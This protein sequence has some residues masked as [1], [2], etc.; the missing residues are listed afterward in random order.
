MTIA[1]QL[2]AL[3]RQEAAPPFEVIV[4]DNGSTD[5]SAE[6]VEALSS[7]APPGVELFVVDCSQRVGVSA[8][9]NAGVKASR[10]DRVLICDADDIV[11]PVWVREMM[12]ALQ[13]YDLVGGALDQATLNPDLVGTVAR[14]LDENLPISLGFL[15]FAMGAN[16]GARRKMIEA[17]GGWDETFIGGGDDVDFSWR[18]Q[19]AGYTI[20]FSEG[21][22]IAYRLRNDLKGACKQSYRYARAGPRL[23]RI[24][25]H[26]GARRRTSRSIV[27]SW[28]WI[29]SRAPV[30][31]FGSYGLRILWCRR[32]GLAFG[33]V[34]GSLRNRVLFL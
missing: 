16:V 8:A 13:T 6:I 11:S 1:D 26:L 5:R 4:A 12:A 9:R 15:P 22:V 30:V 14:R 19:L 28:F 21:A 29:I 20:G 18:A 27:Y 17:I 10:A 3:F 31:A 24:Y 7:V 2:H 23:Y 25:G 34:A 32:V 33:R